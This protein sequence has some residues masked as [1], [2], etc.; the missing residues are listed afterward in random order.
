MVNVYFYRFLQ[1]VLTPL[2][3]GLSARIELEKKTEEECVSML[4]R[5]RTKLEDLTLKCKQVLHSGSD[6]LSFFLSIILI[7][8]YAFLSANN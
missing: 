5:H 4:K 6:M 7:Y 8:K 2:S 1:Q 3:K